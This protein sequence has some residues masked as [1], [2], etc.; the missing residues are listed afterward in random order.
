[1]AGSDISGMIH[2]FI[3]TNSNFLLQPEFE[4]AK[5]TEGLA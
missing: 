2:L 4:T 1:M 3:S 5:G